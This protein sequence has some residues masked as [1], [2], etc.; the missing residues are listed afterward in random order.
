MKNRTKTL[1]ISFSIITV[2][3]T[4]IVVGTFALFSHSVTVEH[5]LQAGSLGAKLERIELVSKTLGSDG[6]LHSATDTQPKEFTNTTSETQNVF[7]LEGESLV[8][9]GTSYEATMKLSN[10]GTV[11]FGYWIEITFKDA[12]P[13]D[14]ASQ[15][16]LYVTTYDEEGNEKVLSAY[17]KDG[18]VIGSDGQPIQKIAVGQSV[19]FKVKVVFEDRIDNNDAQ[20]DK[21]HFDLTV[22]AIQ[23]L[24]K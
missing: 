9:P 3:L 17:A 7:G 12:T 6:Y 21:V 14:L 19:Q 11:A 4:L 18:L 2:C 15:L 23:V 16:K 5:H 20:N 24:E 13:A 1:I 22:S 8:A 10:N